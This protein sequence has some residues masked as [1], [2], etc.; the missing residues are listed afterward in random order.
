MRMKNDFY[1]KGLEPTARFETEAGEL[2]NGLLFLNKATKYWSFLRSI[3]LRGSGG[4]GG[5]KVREIT[6]RPRTGLEIWYR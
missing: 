2:G 1:I 6:P 5:G 4:N 3:F